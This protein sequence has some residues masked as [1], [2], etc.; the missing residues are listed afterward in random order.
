MLT[1]ELPGSAPADFD[2]GVDSIVDSVIT[3]WTIAPSAISSATQL[4]SSG[5]NAN[6][7]SREIMRSQ[8]P[9]IIH[10]LV[11]M[12]FGTDETLYIT[13]GDGGGN[14][15]PNTE[16]NAFNQ[17]RWTNALDPRNVFGSI[18]RIDPLAIP[19]DNRP[20]GGV[21]GQYRIP[22]DNFG[23]TDG[24]PDTHAE[25]F[26]YGFRSPYR[27][28][29]DAITGKVYVGD[30]GESDREEI[31]IVTNGGNYGWGA[32]EGTSVERANLVSS[33]TG[34]IP[35]LFELYHNV[36]G[37]SEAT[38]I[39]GGFVYRGTAIP[40]LHGKYIFADTG[41]DNGGQ[42]TNQVDLYYGD[43]TSTNASSRDD[44]FRLQ[45]ELPDGVNLPDRIWSIAEDE[46]GELYLLVGPDRL[47]LFQRTAEETDGGI[48]KLTAPL[49]VL[50]GIAGDVNQDGFVNGN[51]LGPVSSDDV[52]AFIAGYATTGH[53]SAYDKFTHGDM[54][55]D[56]ATDI[57][58]WYILVQN[59]ADAGGLDLS[60]L[61]NAPVVPE[62]C[63]LTSTLMGFAI[64]IAGFDRRR[65]SR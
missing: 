49:F 30:V 8:R 64:L 39:V 1:S 44:L 26:A 5:P 65:R 10:T 31:D 50:N 28:N 38:N 17:D 14:A 16:G 7:T 13:S 37:Q 55:F 20:T 29:V 12:A 52:S 60:A 9:G 53:Q 19:N 58:D 27:I 63:S 62:P 40:Q 34:A 6:V 3:E 57:R 51:G 22:S 18:L 35:P 43:P 23:L 59:Y 56:G 15:F 47:D 2:D 21:N 25:T 11:D 46:V 24:N 45:I 32:Y 41:E 48:W 36:G 61:L 4:I 54:N 42:P 33:A